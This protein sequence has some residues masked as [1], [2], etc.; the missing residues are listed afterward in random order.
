MSRAPC[1]WSAKRRSVRSSSGSSP[2]LGSIGADLKL[3]HLCGEH[4]VVVGLAYGRLQLGFL[5]QR[6]FEVSGRSERKRLLD[7]G[8]SRGRTRGEAGGKLLS[9]RQQMVGLDHGA[10]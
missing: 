1:A 2:R 7:R 3:L 8:V 9:R 4:P 6:G 10:H 5:R